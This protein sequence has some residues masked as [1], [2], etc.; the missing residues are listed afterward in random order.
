MVIKMDCNCR[1]FLPMIKALIAGLTLTLLLMAV[2]GCSPDK[3]EAWEA[4]TTEQT[5]AEE[6]TEPSDETTQ[7]PAESD[8]ET[9]S[10]EAVWTPFV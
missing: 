6:T 8:S 1:R 9:S 4:S 2:L 7:A 10:S 3:K 5:S